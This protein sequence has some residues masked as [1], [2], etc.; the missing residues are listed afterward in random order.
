MSHRHG[1]PGGAHKYD[2]PSVSVE[3]ATRHQLELNKV[4]RQIPGSAVQRED[5][6][7]RLAIEKAKT[8]KARRRARNPYDFS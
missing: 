1:V 8:A 7:V 2:A 3:E 6:R 5:E 4:A